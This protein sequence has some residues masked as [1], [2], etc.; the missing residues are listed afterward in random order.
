MLKLSPYSSVSSLC[1]NAIQFICYTPL[2]AVVLWDNVSSLF[3]N[4]IIHLLCS[5]VNSS[6][7]RQCQWVQSS[8]VISSNPSKVTY[9]LFTALS[10]SHSMSR[11]AVLVKRWQLHADCMHIIKSFF[12]KLSTSCG[13]TRHL[14]FF[15]HLPWLF[16]SYIDAPILLLLLLYGSGD[17]VTRVSR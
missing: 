17:A 5:F 16:A 11:R 3:N 7:W 6:P 1:N 14:I 15:L 10:K 4:A 9:R 2:S 13:E 8:T 12:C